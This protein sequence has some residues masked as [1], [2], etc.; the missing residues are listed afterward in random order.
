MFPNAFIVNIEKK[1]SIHFNQIGGKRMRG[2]FRDNHLNRVYVDGN[3][4]SIYFARDS[5]TNMVTDMQRSFSSR[6]KVILKNNEVTDLGF[7]TKP[8][9]R[10][11]PIHAVTED[12]KILKG[13]LWKPKDRPISK[14]SI[15]P[16]Y[17]RKHAVSNIPI[18]KKPGAKAA[19]DTLTNKKPLNIKAGQDTTLKKSTIIKSGKDT[20]KSLL[21]SLP[22]IKTQADSLL[23]NQSAIKPVSGSKDTIQTKTPV[24]N[25]PA[26]KAKKDS[27]GK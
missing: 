8:E 9:N 15:L 21:K 4:E 2:F 1:D 26:V 27:I 24:I 19:K 20:T 12:D 10:Y 22:A 6:I 11:I 16:S 25:S 23:K 3:A 5:A 13:F 17:G 18:A 14:E 7:L